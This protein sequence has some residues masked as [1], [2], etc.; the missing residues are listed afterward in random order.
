[1]VLG[2]I[3]EGEIEGGK[4]SCQGDSGGGLFVQDEID[5]KKKF[6]TAGIVSYGDGC[7]TINKPGIYTRTFHYLDWIKKN[8]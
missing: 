2:L 8:M 3:F 1:M 7:G 5:K 4:D 6:I